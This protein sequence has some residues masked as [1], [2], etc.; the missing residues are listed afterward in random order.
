[1]TFKSNNEI[2]VLVVDDEQ[3]IRDLLSFELGSQGYQVVTAVDGVDALEKMRNGKF[4]LVITDLKMPRMGG[5]EALAEIKKID[6]N[7]EVILATGFGTIEAAVSAMKCGAYDFVQKPY[8]IHE[9][10]ALIEKALEKNQLKTLLAL[11]ESSKAIFSTVKLNE[12]LEIVMDLMQ[13]VFSMD[14]GSIML[15]QDD[16][17]LHIAASRGMDPTLARQ[18]QITIGE[19]VAGRVAQNRQARLLINGL[20]DYPE[21]DGVE[22]NLRIT[23]SIVVPFFY[24]DDLMGVLNLS[25][26]KN[27]NHFTQ[28]D[29]TS[30]TIFAAQ[31]SQAVQNAK[32]FQALHEKIDELKKTHQMLDE[33]KNQI[34]GSEK[35]ASIGRLVSGVA[36]ELNNPLTS[37]IGYTDLIIQTTAPGEVK[38]QLTVVFQ[39]AQRCRRIVQDLLVFARWKKPVMKPTDLAGLTDETVEAIKLELEKNKVEI[40]KEYAACSKITADPFQIKQVFGNILTNATHALQENPGQK[41]VEIKILPLDE[42]A[43]VTIR[44]NGPG[45]SRQNLD[46][47]FEPFFSTKEVGKGTGLGLSL[48]YGIVKA[49]GG[50]IWAESEVGKGTTF[51][52]EFPY[53]NRTDAE[54]E[55]EKEQAKITTFDPPPALAGTKILV[56]EYEPSIQNF[57]KTILAHHGCA[58]EVAGDGREA[59]DKLMGTEFEVVFCDYRI[60]VMNGRIVYEQYKKMKPGSSTRFIFVT[61]SAADK[62]LDSFLGENDLFRVMK[63]FTSSE[64]LAALKKISQR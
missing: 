41:C 64:L 62:E 15:L 38:D 8:N 30:A 34:V 5:M 50:R 42:Y 19:R 47:I 23:S 17:K 59:M 18:V 10:S 32:L 7:V 31:V 35:L 58:A 6:P 9:V 3:G 56:I 60:P 1:M 49:H 22:P 57:I 13:K 29:L 45:I 14:E 43:R 40:K 52:L 26:T 20:K 12:L 51:I 4:Q 54:K 55:Q 39:E 21:F 16:G 25:R 46:K 44:D 33:A 48:C 24:Q 27:D 28:A 53:E 37:V 11:Y 61:G 2:R 36:H 63:P